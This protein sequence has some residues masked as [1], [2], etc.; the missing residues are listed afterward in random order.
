MNKITSF[1][2]NIRDTQKAAFSY[3]VSVK[4]EKKVIVY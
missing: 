2:F 3:K 1:L 4:I